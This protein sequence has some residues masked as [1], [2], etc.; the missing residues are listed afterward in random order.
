[1]ALR[2]SKRTLNALRR[3]VTGDDAQTPTVAAPPLP[4]TCGS[5][6]HWWR[7]SAVPHKHALRAPCRRYPPVGA[8][9]GVPQ[10]PDDYSCGEH[11]HG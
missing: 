9:G 11:Q 3:A 7:A 8:L 5:C 1:M 4:P 6:R 2:M 10:V